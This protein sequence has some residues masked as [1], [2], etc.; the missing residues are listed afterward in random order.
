MAEEV[1]SIQEARSMQDVLST[2]SDGLFKQNPRSQEV[3]RVI[4][5]ED[6]LKA[7]W[8]LRDKCFPAD[9][10]VSLERYQEHY[11]AA[12]HLCF[13]YFD[14]EKLRGF[15]RGGSQK[16]EHLPPDSCGALHDPDGETMV[17]HLLCVEEQSRR[18][19]I[20]QA[21]MKAF[22]DYVKAKETK[23]KR[24]ILMCHA[25]LI[26]VYTRVGFTLVGRAEVKFGKRSWYECCLDLTTYDS[27]ATDDTFQSKYIPLATDNLNGSK[28]FSM[29]RG[30]ANG[31]T[32][33]IESEEE[34]EELKALD[35]S[36]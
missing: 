32:I 30:N 23:V 15:L 28:S 33:S 12:P 22:I 20:G 5:N 7:A 18:R 10:S 27:M 6:E 4:C 2:S 11:R 36:D 31:S 26:P 13:G 16:G 14:G 34:F 25:E 9:E 24:V 8:M 3:I 35:Y 17:L 1:S 21:L 29:T 19:G